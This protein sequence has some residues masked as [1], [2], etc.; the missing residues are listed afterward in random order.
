[1]GR[2]KDW[3]EYVYVP[4]TDK[5]TG[6]RTLV[7]TKRVFVFSLK[8]NEV[9]KSFLEDWKTSKEVSISLGLDS[10]K[11]KDTG[12][13]VSRCQQKFVSK[14]W[15]NKKKDYVKDSVTSKRKGQKVPHYKANIEPFIWYS[16]ELA[17][18]WKIENINFTKKIPFLYLFFE[19]PEIRKRIGLYEIKYIKNTFG[20]YDSFHLIVE[21]NLIY[22][23]MFIKGFLN[24]RYEEY[25][26]IELGLIKKFLFTENIENLIKEYL[27]DKDSDFNKLHIREK[28]V[29]IYNNNWNEFIKTIQYKK[30]KKIKKR[31][32]TSEMTDDLL[33]AEL[34]I[35]FYSMFFYSKENLETFV[36]WF[37][38][39]LTRYIV[40][41]RLNEF[42]DPKNKEK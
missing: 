31:F 30:L 10:A 26:K 17:N 7:K 35:Q 41:S 15:L 6:E 34:K 36:A 18:D 42:Y 23:W 9:F 13:S 22:N 12:S 32:Y 3:R 8:D 20:L 39:N 28:I 5:K 14:N 40:N 1:M 37:S 38:S 19:L 33:D 25:G 24:P 21:D 11:T 4:K 27:E 29:E 2:L 16:F